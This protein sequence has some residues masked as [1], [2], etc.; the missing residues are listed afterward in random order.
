MAGWKVIKTLKDEDGTRRLDI[1]SGDDG[2]FYCFQLFDWM[3]AGE[4][5]E[6]ALGDG[7]W[8]VSGT[9]GLFDTAD[10]CEREAQRTVDWLK[11]D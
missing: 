4:E 8:Q 10:A 9:S 7:F 5:D 1:Q 3:P 2:K 6:G 11:E